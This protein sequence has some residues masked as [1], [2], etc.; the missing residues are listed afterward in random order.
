M[1]KA[2]FFDIDGVLLDSF[3]ANLKFYSTLMI[4]FGFKAPTRE[5]FPDIFLA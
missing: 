2:V 1:I 4:K 3:E 5:N